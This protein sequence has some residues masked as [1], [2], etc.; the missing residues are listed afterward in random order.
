MITLERAIALAAQAHEGVKDRGGSPYIL[1]PL[2]IMLAQDTLDAMIVAV[3]HDVLEDVDGWGEARLLAEGFTE[4]HIRALEALTKR[5][6]EQGTVE[7][8]ARFVARAGANPLARSVKLADLRDNMDLS[9]IPMPTDR[10]RERQAKYERAF[11]FLDERV[12]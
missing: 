11:R 12:V 2:R 4:A 3:M 10:D 9:R 1:H 8:Y 6:E 7:G 5:P